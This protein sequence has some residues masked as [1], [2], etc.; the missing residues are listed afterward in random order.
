MIA[1]ISFIVATDRACFRRMHAASPAFGAA[2]F[3]DRPYP[4]D[5]RPLRLHG[6]AGR[7]GGQALH[8]G[9]RR[10]RRR[11]QDRGAPA[12]RRRTPPETTKR[13]AQELVTN[14]HAEIL[15]GFGLTPLAF[16]AAPIATA[17]KVPMIVMSR[18]HPRHPAEVALHHAHL[19]YPA[20][21]HGAHRGVGRQAR[22]QEGLHPGHRLRPRH[23][24]RD[25]LQDGLHG[26]W[27]PDR[28]RGARARSRT[29]TMRPSSSAPRTPSLTRCSSSCP[30][31][32][33][34]R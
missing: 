29:R 15:A 9:A 32:K 22:H 4:A 28:R 12:R 16:A 13:F 26:E 17:A 19:V 10:R 6:E 23:R 11:P 2:A 33:A 24:L 14:D 8:R 34:R 5:D 31:A 3:E 21:E 25:D 20:A 7:R 18:G 30:R 1:R 27:R